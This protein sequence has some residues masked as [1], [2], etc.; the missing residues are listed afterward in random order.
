MWSRTSGEIFYMVSKNV[1]DLRNKKPPS[2]GQQG[3]FSSPPERPAKRISKVRVRRRRTRIALF[4][5]IMLLI[6]TLTYT[7]SW[8]SYLPQYSVQSVSVVG[9]QAVPS[10]VIRDYVETL[11]K[12][13]GHPFLSTYNIFLYHPETIAREIVNY[14]PRVASADVSR[15]SLLATAVTV[16]IEERQPYALWCSDSSHTDCYEMD[17]TGFIFAQLPP[18]E[19][20][21][22]SSVTETQATSTNAMASSTEGMATTSQSQSQTLETSQTSMYVFEGGLSSQM[23]I[24]TSTASTSATQVSLEPTQD[25]SAGTAAQAASNISSSP[26]GQT[27]A[28]SHMGEIVAL[29]EL[30]SQAGFT[31][32]GAIV[33]NDQDFWV[34]LTQGFYIKASFGENPQNLVSNLQ[35]VLSSSVLQGKESQLEYVDLRFG[36]RVYYKL[37]GQGETQTSS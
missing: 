9:A 3:L 20:A 29:L 17:H 32:T 25:V 28:P 4:F 26:I 33:E 27:F 21:A 36:D 10:D 16:T 37:Q 18:E 30:L 8:A 11:L 24:A 6:G 14:F 13:N 12:S 19:L 22:S 2:S 34:P 23:Q 15:D 7:V 5:A 35:L 31:P 1:I